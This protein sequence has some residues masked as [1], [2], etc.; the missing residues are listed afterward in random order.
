LLDESSGIPDA[1][2]AT[3]EAALSSCVEGHI[4]QAGNPT[5]R[6]GP[7][8]RAATTERRLWRV[9]EVNGDPDNP[10]RSPR[11]SIEW[12]RQ[13]I[14][15]YGRENPFVLISVFGRF[16][17]SSLNT[18]IG[19]DEVRAATLQ[20]YREQDIA[21]HPRILGVDVARFGDDS[22]IV[23][24]RQGLVAFDPLQYRNIDGTQG[25][26]LVARK[27]QDWDA[28]ACFVDDTGG[29][30]ASWI[31][32]LIR[33]GRTPIGVGFA[34]K[35]DDPRYAN[36]R[37]EMA[38]ECV[39]WVKD[40][41]RIPDIPELRAA[42]TETTYTFQGDRLLVEPKE[43]IKA[44]LGYSPDHFDALMITFAAPVTRMHA[45]MPGMRH[46]GHEFEY[47]PFASFWNV[48][49]TPQRHRGHVFEYDPFAEPWNA[50]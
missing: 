47:D 36:K 18:L 33:L 37:A 9:F 35:P 17:P 3:A 10:K 34:G 31:D 41:G 25:A 42:M 49:R 13:Q 39:A 15:K 28:D 14:E 40:G 1:V 29:Y 26:G 23:F 2:M 38:F 7:L 11:V 20:Q 44:R 22:S 32:N 5:H 48:E 8:Y 6:T 45:G 12:A 24:P 27:W 21:N 43:L 50:G 4:V 30:G 46:R 16:P 19:P